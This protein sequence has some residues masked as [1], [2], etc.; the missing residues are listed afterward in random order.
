MIATTP[1]SSF[2]PAG[3]RRGWLGVGVAGGEA[4]GVGVGS[5][6]ACG[7]GSC[8]AAAA[9]ALNEVPEAEWPS[10]GLSADAGLTPAQTAST[11]ATRPAKRSLITTRP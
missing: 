3:I 2:N 11:A 7:L 1:I 4:C 10:V 5:G 6:E 9:S 8:V